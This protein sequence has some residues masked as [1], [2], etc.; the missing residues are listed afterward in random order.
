MK[1][2]LSDDLIDFDPIPHTYTNTRTRKKYLGVTT[3]IG[4]FEPKFDVEYWSAREAVKRLYNE[5]SSKYAM[6]RSV[7]SRVEKID[8]KISLVDKNKVFNYIL[9]SPD[10]NQLLNLQNEVKIEW[11]NKNTVAIE[12]GSAYHQRQEDKLNYNE[13]R[14][15]DTGLVRKLADY[16]QVPN[17]I[18]NS[19][20]KINLSYYLPDGAYAEIL[21]RNHKY[22]LCGQ[23]D[24]VFIETINGVRYVDIDDFKTNAKLTTSNKYDTFLKPLDF[25]EHHKFNIYLLQINLYAW[26][27]EQ[28]GFVIRR[29]T[30]T[31][32]PNMTTKPIVH[33]LW[34][35]TTEQDP[36]KLM[37]NV[38]KRQLDDL[39]W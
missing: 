26:M 24:Y 10:K 28:Y 3:F 31:H 19:A 32:Q 16:S 9:K 29:L 11:K 27:A 21:M 6:F 30:L 8:G 14:I 18:I 23:A 37:L 2:Y 25:L 20:G 35:F 33:K 15:I 39:N 4:Q 5:R 12:K 36:I 22:E 13:F 17:E 38:R 1:D 34:K 7:V